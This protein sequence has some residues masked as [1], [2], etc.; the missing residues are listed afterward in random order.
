VKK[1][2]QLLDEEIDYIHV[3][4]ME[5]SK[6]RHALAPSSLGMLGVCACIAAWR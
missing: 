2:P 4:V 5:D 3:R 6:P 1:K